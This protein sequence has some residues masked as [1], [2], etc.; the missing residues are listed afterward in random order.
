[1]SP[2]RF[3]TR[4]GETASSYRCW[5]TFRLV[6]ADAIFSNTEIA[7]CLLPGISWR[8]MLKKRL[9][10]VWGLVLLLFTPKQTSFSFSLSSDPFDHHLHIGYK[11]ENERLRNT[12]DFQS[13]VTLWR[14]PNKCLSSPKPAAA[15]YKRRTGQNERERQHPGLGNEK[16]KIVGSL[17][18]RIS[19]K[20]SCEGKDMH[21]VQHR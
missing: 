1:M 12:S 9:M 11:M 17:C 8:A 15:S 20:A 2:R 13:S 21:F 3:L 18:D 4:Q 6:N 19:S 5:N 14:L 7:I 10:R 16:V